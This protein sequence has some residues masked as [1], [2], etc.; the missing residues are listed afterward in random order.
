METW[1][2]AEPVHPQ[3]PIPA[4]GGGNGRG[5]A[6]YLYLSESRTQPG[7]FHERHVLRLSGQTALAR[8]QAWKAAC[9]SAATRMPWDCVEGGEQIDLLLQ[10]V[11][12]QALPPLQRKAAALTIEHAC[13][14][15]R[16]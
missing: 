7:H 8:M 11:Q 10:W 5:L 15:L 16:A 2:R 12:A 9:H 3:H 6:L 14:Q 1:A 13:R 4:A